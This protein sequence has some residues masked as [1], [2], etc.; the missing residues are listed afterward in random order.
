MS[1]G[2]PST[3]A[4]VSIP[5]YCLYAMITLLMR[6]RDRRQYSLQDLVVLQTWLDAQHLIAYGVHA[7]QVLDINALMVLATVGALAIG[8]YTEGAAV[9][10][11]FAV[12]AWLE[13]GCGCK[14]RDVVSD[15]VAMQPAIATLADSGKSTCLTLEMFHSLQD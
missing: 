12:A 5:A 2:Q 4:R 13:A 11:L 1:Y 15:V 14:A 10:V 6:Q 9:V 8:D 7:L 3:A